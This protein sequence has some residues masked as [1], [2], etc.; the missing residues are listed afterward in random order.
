MVAGY[1]ML[2]F[3]ALAVIGAEGFTAG[4]A[5]FPITFLQ[6]VANR[7]ALIK[8]ETIAFPFA[9]LGWDFFKVL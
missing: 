6:A 8:D 5:N 2:E 4:V 1:S 9:L 3:F 7:Y